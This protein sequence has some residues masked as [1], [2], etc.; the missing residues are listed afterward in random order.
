MRRL[1]TV[2]PA[3]FL[4]AACGVPEAT[5]ATV[6]AAVA[7]PASSGSTTA[8]PTSQPLGVVPVDM[9]PA[10]ARPRPRAVAPQAADLNAAPPSRPSGQPVARPTARPQHAPRQTARPQPAAQEPA[11]QPSAAGQASG[12]NATYTPCVPND[13]VDVD[14]EGSNGPSYVTGP[15][16]VVGNDVYGLDADHDANGCE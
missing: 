2:V 12:C 3:V 15:V 14:C 1:L 11:P 16:T 6:P 9:G 8:R 13:A 4:L 10:P 5:S 7:A